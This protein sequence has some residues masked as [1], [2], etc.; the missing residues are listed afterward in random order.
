MQEKFESESAAVARFNE[1][2]KSGEHDFIR[3]IL[4]IGA[5]DITPTY[6]VETE[7]QIIRTWERDEQ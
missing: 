7:P 3:I 4:S 5:R 6:F 1:L 2:K